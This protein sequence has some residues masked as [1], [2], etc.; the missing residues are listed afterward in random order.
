[1]FENIRSRLVLVLGILLCLFTLVEVNFPLMQQEISRLAVFVMLGLVLCFLV[2]PLAKRFADVGWLRF[3][4]LGLAL[5]SVLCCGYVIVQNESLNQVFST[6]LLSWTGI[7]FAVEPFWFDGQSLGDRAGKENWIDTVFGLTGLVLVLEATRRAIGW[8]VPVLA[9]LVVLHSFYGYLSDAKNLRYRAD[10]FGVQRN[11]VGDP[12]FRPAAERN[13]PSRFAIGNLPAAP[14]WMMIRSGEGLQALSSTTFLKGVFGIPA[15]VMFKYVFLFV[16]FGA[17]LELSGATSFII[18][19]A[20]R[21]FSRFTGGPALVSVMGSGM[22]GS[23]SGSA[24]ANAMMTGSFAI[25]MMRSDGF[26]RQTAGGITAAAATGGALVPPVM[27]AGAYMMLE[28]V[29]PSVSFLQI[30]QAALIP[31]VLYYLSLLLIVY[32]YACRQRHFG[33]VGEQAEAG[34]AP[35]K[36]N[37]FDGLVFFLALA[38]LLSLMFMS[39]TPFKAVSGSL[40]VILV[41][42]CFR[43]S[44]GDPRRQTTPID[45]SARWVMLLSFAIGTLGWAALQALATDRLAE[46]VNGRKIFE[47]LLDSALI[48]MC[49]MILIGLFHPTWQP[50]LTGALGKSAKNGIALV[51]AS[52]CVGIIIGVVTQTGVASVF[53]S[54]IKSVVETNLL[55]ALVGIMFCSIIL[56]MGVPS[57]VCYLL[58]ATL[59]AN[60]LG[61]MGVIPLGAHLFIFYF[62]MMSMV[63]PPVAL[64]AYASASIAE[65]PVMRTAWSAFRFSLVGFTLPFMFVYRPALMLMNE[66]KWLAWMQAPDNTTEKQ[67]LLDAANS[68]WPEAS[69]LIIALAAALLGILAL[70]SAIAGFLRG[71]LKP[72]ARVGLMI[73]AALLLLPV[74]EFNGRDVGMFVNIAGGILLA[75]LAAAN[76]WGN[77]QPTT[78]VP[79][80][81]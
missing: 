5:L 2:Y 1:M 54:N 73:A 3:A 58:V 27:G 63:T 60:L 75:G 36:V 66:Q 67:Q 37:L 39:F 28:L 64:A 44:I 38:T 71:P 14:K 46:E 7:Q 68:A 79:L 77:R 74:I 49:L 72:A 81:Q 76:W 41:M 57:V 31:A 21:V 6:P 61:D 40:V 32:F 15:G 4:D 55:L 8:I 18:D 69:N 80:P 11:E 23:L 29:K 22:M 33:I 24:V 19:F 13:N 50:S 34:A 65:S 10:V 47:L 78:G 53:S 62:G 45:G 20:R 70:A 56:G 16:I 52:A 51:A 59:M 35:I 43:S 26:E 12:V 17:F 42:T 30:A 48:G 9:I 25:P